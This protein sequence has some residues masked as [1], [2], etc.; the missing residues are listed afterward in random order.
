MTSP[1]TLTEKE[2]K[3]YDAMRNLVESLSL[4]NKKNCPLVESDF[5]YDSKDCF[6]CKFYI[7]RKLLE[8]V[9]ADPETI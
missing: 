7:A 9:N 8:E 4:H 5:C 6:D 2:A 1:Y 3:L